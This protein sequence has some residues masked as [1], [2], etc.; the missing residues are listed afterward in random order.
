[1]FSGRQLD[2]ITS[3]GHV[4]I[5]LLCCCTPKS[6]FSFDAMHQQ[7]I[8]LAAAEKNKLTFT[9][10]QKVLVSRVLAALVRIAVTVPSLK[11]VRRVNVK[12]V[13]VLDKLH[14]SRNTTRHDTFPTRVIRH[15][16]E[17]SQGID[18]I[19]NRRVNDSNQVASGTLSCLRHN[20]HEQSR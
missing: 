6:T 18:R 13:D 1:M 3:R 10:N 16:D 7:G 11:V 9:V 5:T 14:T 19:L 20:G 2:A 17:V 15:R 12:A 8:T 4:F